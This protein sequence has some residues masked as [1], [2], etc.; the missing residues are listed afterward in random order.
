MVASFWG[1]PGF[2]GVWPGRD[3]LSKQQDAQCLIQEVA[4]ALPIPAG[5]LLCF[6]S[7]LQLLRLSPSAETLSAKGK[8]KTSHLRVSEEEG[9]L[10]GCRQNCTLKTHSHNDNG[11]G[12]DHWKQM[13][14][15]RRK[16]GLSTCFLSVC[17]SRLEC[18]VQLMVSISLKLPKAEVLM[19]LTL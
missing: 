10:Q 15:M 19:S 11:C 9:R 14:L 4:L 2:A 8:G 13:A 6:S 1:A 18:G 17:P 5:Y 12:Y 3:P 16:P 7:S